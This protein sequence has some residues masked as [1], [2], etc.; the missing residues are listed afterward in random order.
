[1]RIGLFSNPAIWYGVATMAV[2]Q[3][4]LSYAPLMNRLFATASIGIQEWLEIF[5]V[6]MMAS[7][8]VG[9]DKRWSQRAGG[10][11][12]RGRFCRGIGPCRQKGL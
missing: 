9:I 1:L 11:D 7:L 12:R 5:A 2:L 6:G 3:L 8:V 10:C 4:L